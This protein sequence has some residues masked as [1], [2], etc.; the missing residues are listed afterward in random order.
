[1]KSHV[2][3][4]L[5][6]ESVGTRYRRLRVCAPQIAREAKPGQYMHVLP[7]TAGYDPLLRRA[8]S[9]LRCQDD[10]FEMLYRIEGRGTQLLAQRTA[11][12]SLDALGPLGQPF[13]PIRRKVLLVGGGIGVPPLVFLAEN[14]HQACRESSIVSRETTIEAFVG[15][16][17][18]EDMVEEESLRA[19]TEA[20]TIASQ[21]GSRG[22]SGLVTQP[23]ERRLR[24]LVANH[25]GN[26]SEICSV[27]ACGPWPMLRAVAQLCAAYQVR[28]Q[29]SMEENMPCGIGVC[30]GCVVPMLNA[31]DEYERFQRICVVGPV[32][33]ARQID[34]GTTAVTAGLEDGRA[35]S[36]SA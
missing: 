3:E 34:W 36:E 13:A 24:E 29:V 27:R 21:D 10:W 20:L 15:V 32:M 17:S 33:D 2:F 5:Q 6:H 25:K 1:M 16:R 19:A 22:E 8:F 28:C 4:I 11:G 7:G 9:I 18:A 23:L 35:A 31:D 26:E 30:N 12:D 14:H